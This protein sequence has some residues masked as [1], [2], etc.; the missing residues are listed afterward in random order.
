MEHHARHFALVVDLPNNI[1][2]PTIEL[3]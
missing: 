2:C 3:W 1:L